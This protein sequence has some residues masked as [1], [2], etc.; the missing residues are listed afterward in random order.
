MAEPI[1][2]VAAAILPSE[3]PLLLLP[4]RIETVLDGHELQI[5][6]YPDEIHLDR[7]PEQPGGRPTARPRLLPDRFMATG[8]RDGRASS[9]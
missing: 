7:R 1:A 5:R 4:I 9:P 6:V 3:H 8:W 2:D